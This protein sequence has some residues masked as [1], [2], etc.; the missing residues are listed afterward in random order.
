MNKNRRTQIIAD[1]GTRDSA[2]D[3]IFCYGD[4]MTLTI[5]LMLVAFLFFAAIRP[6][7]GRRA[8]SNLTAAQTAASTPE[9]ST[10]LYANQFPG[11]DID[12]KINAAFDA[13]PG[14]HCEVR[15]SNN[16]SKGYSASTT[17]IVPFVNNGGLKLTIE[18]GTVISFTGT[19]DW[20][21]YFATGAAN[22]NNFVLEMAG[23]KVVGNPSAGSCIHFRQ[24]VHAAVY[25]AY[26]AGFTNGSSVA[27]GNGE[28]DEGSIDIFRYKPLYVGNNIG[29]RETGYSGG[30]GAPSGSANNAVYGGRFQANVV[31][32]YLADG[33]AGN[34]LLDA[35]NIL[36]DVDVEGN[37]RNPV[38]TH[39]LTA[40]GNGMMVTVTGAGT[41]TGCFAGSYAVQSGFSN[42]SLNFNPG[43]VLVVSATPNTY[44]YKSGVTGTAA[45][46][47]VTCQHYQVFDE[48][49]SNFT[50]AG[51]FEQWGASPSGFLAELLI[52]DASFGPHGT[53]VSGPF[54][55]SIGS[56]NTI[57]EYVATG[58]VVDGN[59]SEGDSI[60]AFFT[61]GAGSHSGL[62]ILI[63]PRNSAAATLIQGCS[64]VISPAIPANL[65]TS[66]N[67]SDTVSI[68]GMTPRGHCSLSAANESAAAHIASTFISSY[69]PGQITVTHAT[70]AGMDYTLLCT[71]N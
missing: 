63:S 37:G 68:I 42:S 14:S 57:F 71:P 21:D 26:C 25:N 17:I 70:A 1:T 55:S 24:I 61:C 20:L 22:N 6:A 46:G 39:S 66:S 28:L 27:V 44:S 32:G 31:G 36:Q 47:T 7:P 5:R 52:G 67:T 65:T 4:S 15:V 12:A 59:T 50:L 48:A 40:G 9:T 60:P 69:G 11:S 56:S 58:T 19:D 41:A 38:T 62:Q 54:F 29:L 34:G 35:S 49:G 10:I 23:A 2:K 30:S 64:S 33:L 8:F 16:Q 53:R 13:C 45:N 51:G 18:P 3:W 43:G